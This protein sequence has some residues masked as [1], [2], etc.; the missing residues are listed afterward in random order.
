MIERAH[1][2]RRNLNA[3]YYADDGRVLARLDA[4]DGPHDCKVLLRDSV[5]LNF[6]LARGMVFLIT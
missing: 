3:I 6:M 4:M 1:W 2:V 5:F